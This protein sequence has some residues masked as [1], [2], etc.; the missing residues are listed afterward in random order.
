[1]QLYDDVEL[2]LI[3]D[4]ADFA[5]L[6]GHLEVFLPEC[7]LDYADAGAEFDEERADGGFDVDLAQEA[8]DYVISRFF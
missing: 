3:P 5:L 8:G 6:V 4:F 7:G 1:M 2:S